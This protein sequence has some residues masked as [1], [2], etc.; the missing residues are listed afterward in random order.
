LA[1]T[2]KLRAKILNGKSV[3]IVGWGFTKDIKSNIKLKYHLTV[4]SMY[5]C[6]KISSNRNTWNKQLCAISNGTSCTTD[7]GGPLMK[8]H[9]DGKLNYWYLAGI[10]SRGNCGSNNGVGVFTRVSEYFDWIVANVLE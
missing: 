1:S 3:D 2:A 9:I 4:V 8:E 7:L 5:Q 6:R 10:V